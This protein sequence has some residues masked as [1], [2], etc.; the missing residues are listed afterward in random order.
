MKS[1]PI[2]Q[3]YRFKLE[4]EHSQLNFYNACPPPPPPPPPPPQKQKPHPTS[5]KT[6]KKDFL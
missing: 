6:K 1:S 2:W 4:E 3:Q 5:F